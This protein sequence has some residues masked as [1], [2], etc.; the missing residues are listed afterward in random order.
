MTFYPPPGAGGTGRNGSTPGGT[1]SQRQQ[2]RGDR[3]RTSNRSR[4]S[5]YH[6]HVGGNTGNGQANGRTAAG[7]G[8]GGFFNRGARQGGGGGHSPLADPEFFSNADIRAYCERSRMVFL[9]L[10]FELAGAAEVLQGA[11]KEIPDAEGRRFG[12]LVRARRVSR[13]LKKVADDARDAA[14][15][16]AA[17]YAAFQREYSPELGPRTRPRRR[18]DFTD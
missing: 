14:K 6:F 1:G 5:H 18:F 10:A 12:S 11:L 3:N 7:G 16:S 17:T 4:S 15:N 8:R 2:A 9:Q 13:K